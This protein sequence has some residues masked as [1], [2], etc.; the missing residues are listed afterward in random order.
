MSIKINENVLK[1]YKSKAETFFRDSQSF[2]GDG[3][4]KIKELFRSSKI[5]AI[6]LRN[7]LESYILKNYDKVSGVEKS[8]MEEYLKETKELLFKDTA[9]F[10]F[11]SNN[12]DLVLSFVSFLSQNQSLILGS[13][14]VKVIS[15]IIIDDS[16]DNNPIT[17]FTTLS[18]ITAYITNEKKK[19]ETALNNLVKALERGIMSNTTNKRL[20]ELENA[21]EELERKILYILTRVLKN[22]DKVLLIIWLKNIL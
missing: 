5:S 19:A 12:E 9:S 11:T 2:A 6:E 20:N 4:D 16:V 14:V 8:V 13:K 10:D 17:E 3:K 15:Y 7:V 18:P 1:R 22:L 21:I